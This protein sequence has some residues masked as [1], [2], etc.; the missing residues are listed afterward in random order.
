MLMLAA[1]RARVQWRLLGAL[2]CVVAVGATLL[3][4]CALLVTDTGDR[5]LEVAAARAGAGDVEVTAY[6]AT[7]RGQ[8]AASVAADTRALLTSTL[9]PLPVTMSGQASSAM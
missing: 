7:I 4:V 5:A 1:R 3:G 2:L 8:D 9:A 6:T